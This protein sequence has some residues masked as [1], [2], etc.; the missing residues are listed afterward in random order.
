MT[1]VAL[2]WHN[3][4]TFTHHATCQ[5]SKFCVG[6]LPS[7]CTA[8]LGPIQTL[9][10]SHVYSHVNKYVCKERLLPHLLFRDSCLRRWYSH[11]HAHSLE[12]VQNS[13]F[14][15]KGGDIFHLPSSSSFCLFESIIVGMLVHLNSVKISQ[16]KGFLSHQRTIRY[17]R[18]QTN[19]SSDDRRGEKLEFKAASGPF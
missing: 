2:A 9:R 5:V 16:I 14:R 12:D 7:V 4:H 1:T 6:L 3:F 13:I 10:C 18:D 17:P 8:D 15:A 19:R 11:W